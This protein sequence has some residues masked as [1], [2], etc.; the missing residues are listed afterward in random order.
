MAITSTD[1]SLTARLTTITRDAT[2]SAR[3]DDLPARVQGI[4]S[5]HEMTGEVLVKLIQILVAT[6]WI[7]LYAVSRKT[8]AGTSFSPVPYALAAY[9][10]LS[11]GGLYFALRRP[12]PAWAVY[13]SSAVDVCLLMLLIWSFHIQYGQPAAFYLKAPTL[14][15]VFIFIALR[16]LRFEP[17]FVLATGGFAALGWMALV[18]VAIFE[19]GEGTRVTRDYIHYM[20]SNS[21]LI[22]AE[23]DKI[24]SI[25]LVSAVIA[26]ALNRANGFLVRATAEAVNVQ[27]LSRF[28]D[29]SVADRIKDTESPLM[30]GDNA[31]REAAILFVDIRG[32][33]PMSALLDAEAVVTMLT[34]YQTRIVPI[35]QGHG[36][37]IDKFL[38]DGIMATFG[39]VKKSDTPAADALR[40]LDAIIVETDTWGPDDGCLAD[41]PRGSVNGATTVGQVVFGVVGNDKRLEY[42]VIGDP[43]N[44]AAKLEKLNRTVRSRAVTSALTLRVAI[45]QGYSPRADLRRLETEYGEVVV[46]SE[47]LAQKASG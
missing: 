47:T 37:V 11:A 45:A 31:R 13:L 19:E 15:Y 20:T 35:I 17:R 22:G 21:I 10:L 42:T 7:T 27:D 26:L 16:A 33:T 5:E 32:F 23:F 40:A 39:A 44:L 8:D 29:Q 25:L 38:G 36:G 18:L 6:I 24:G 9:F 3:T 43:V 34:A 2:R 41:L 14:L 46:L 1:L 4:V 12:L 30:A 28:F